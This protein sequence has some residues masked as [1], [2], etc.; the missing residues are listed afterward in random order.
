[1]L[2]YLIPILT[3]HYCLL[4]RSRLA[5]HKVIGPEELTH[6]R[7]THRVHGA[8]LQIDEHCAWHILAA[9]CLV[10]VDIDALVLQIRFAMIVAI[11]IDAMLVRD[12]LPE[13]EEKEKEKKRRDEFTVPSS[14]GSAC[15][16]CKFAYVCTAYA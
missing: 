7:L 1:M 12:D 8:W 16:W 10:V 9:A 2:F 3:A 5:V 6:G 15:D 11:G 14:G 4:T 13:L